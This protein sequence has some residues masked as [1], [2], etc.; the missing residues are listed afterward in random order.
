MGIPIIIGAQ[1]G[2]KS[3]LTGA[4]LTLASQY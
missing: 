1:V 2:E 3:I 4:S